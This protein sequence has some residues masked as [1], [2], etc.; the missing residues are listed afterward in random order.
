M[1]TS[2]IFFSTIGRA[3][4]N[5]SGPLVD[6]TALMGECGKGDAATAGAC[7]GGGGATGTGAGAGAG[8]GAAG[9]GVVVSLMGSGVV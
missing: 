5:P 4:D 3:L 7:A 2:S 1:G 8:A 6:M 9:V